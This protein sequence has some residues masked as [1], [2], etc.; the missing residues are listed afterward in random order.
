[1]FVPHQRRTLHACVNDCKPPI[2]PA[3]YTL[4]V[5]CLASHM[6]FT[7][8]GCGVHVGMHTAALIGILGILDMDISFP[9]PMNVIELSG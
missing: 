1:M 5:A 9:S 3:N 2:I 6:L 7:G 8:G 4:C